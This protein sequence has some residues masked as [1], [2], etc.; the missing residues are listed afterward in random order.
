MQKE[1]EKRV[2]LL[3]KARDNLQLQQVELKSCELDI[4]YWFRNYVY[5]D[6]NDR[7]YRKELPNVLPFIPYPFQEECVLHVWDCINR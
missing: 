1:L 4:L 5:T 6:K 3:G 7:L 2:T